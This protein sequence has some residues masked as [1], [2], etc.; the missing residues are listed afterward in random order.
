MSGPVSSTLM[1]GTEDVSSVT[2]AGCAALVGTRG[3]SPARALALSCTR[4]L[5][6]R[7]WDLR[8]RPPLASV[9]RKSA[10]FF[11]AESGSFI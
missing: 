10:I 1:P 9:W 11:A 4:P 3:G 7:I 5:Q 2:V 8:S 6:A